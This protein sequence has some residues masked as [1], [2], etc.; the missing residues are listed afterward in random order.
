MKEMRN[1]ATQR[2]NERPEKQETLQEHSGLNAQIQLTEPKQSQGRYKTVKC[3]A[4][5]PNKHTG[6]RTFHLTVNDHSYLTRQTDTA[7]AQLKY[8]AVIV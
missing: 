2:K 1:N 8:L 3:H 5:T 7:T 6:A 4:I